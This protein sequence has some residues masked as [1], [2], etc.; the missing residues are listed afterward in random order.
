MD[1]GNTYAFWRVGQRVERKDGAEQGTVVAVDE[2]IKVKW[3][4]GATSYF[5]RG[6]W[7]KLRL[8]PPA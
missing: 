1:T 7:E 6:E 5:R 2:T 4:G 3:D 8:M